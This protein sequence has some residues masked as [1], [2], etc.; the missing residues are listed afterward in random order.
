[1]QEIRLGTIGSGFIV[2][3]ILNNVRR[4]EGIRLAAV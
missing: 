3:Q 2:H 1:M 4:V